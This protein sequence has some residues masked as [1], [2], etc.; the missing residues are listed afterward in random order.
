MAIK[1]NVSLDKILA[2]KNEFDEQSQAIIESLQ[3]ASSEI[4]AINSMKRTSGWKILQKKIREELVER[5]EMLVKDDLQVKTL[6]ALLKV[7]D[8]KSL[9]RLLDE[10][11]ESILPDG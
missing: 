5:I 7:A 8:T 11:I 1:R 6:L 3:F 10:S 9:S 4:D 2:V